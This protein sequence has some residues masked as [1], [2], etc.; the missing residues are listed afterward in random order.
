M[1][2]IQGTRELPQSSR[3]KPKFFLEPCFRSREQRERGA[4]VNNVK[5]GLDN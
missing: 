5:V 2:I 4:H 1:V 3:E